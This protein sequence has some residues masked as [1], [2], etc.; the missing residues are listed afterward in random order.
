MRLIISCF[1]F[2]LPFITFSQ[3]KVSA[4]VKFN[5]QPFKEAIVIIEKKYKVRFSYSENLIDSSIKISLD[6]RE[7]TLEEVLIEIESQTNL[8]FERINVRYIIIKTKDT[9]ENLNNIQQLDKVLITS[10]LSRGISKNKDGSFQINPNKLQ[11]LPGVVEPDVLESLQQFPGVVSLNET[12]SGMNIRGGNFDQNQILWDGINIYHKGH[13][14]GMISQFNPHITE[15]VSLIAKGTDPKYGERVS[16]IIE[17]KSNTSIQN[18]FEAAAGINGINWDAMLKIPIIKDTLSFQT[19]FRRSLFDLHQSFTYKQLSNKVFQNTR[20]STVTNADNQ[21]SFSDAT[22]KINYK[23][24]NKNTL[25]FSAITINNSLNYILHEDDSNVSFT[26]RLTSS[27]YGVSL[28]WN[29]IYTENIQQETTAHYSNYAF[30]YN[31]I[32]SENEVQVSDFIKRNTILDSG[33]TTEFQFELSPNRKITFGYQYALKDAKYAFLNTSDLSFILDSD[34]S[35]RSTHAL[36]GKFNYRKID[37]WNISLGLRGSYFPE[38]HTV[39]LAPRI[40]ILKPIMKNL[41][42]QLT[43]ELKNQ[44]IS[45]VN[46][47]VFSNFSLENTIW[48][49][50]NTENV[51]IISSAQVSLGFLYA[52]NGLTFDVDSYY[53]SID[54]ITALS[55]GFLNPNM[56]NFNIGNQYIKGVEVFL[57]KKLNQLEAW[58]SYAY[59][60]SKSKYENLNNNQYFRSSTEINHAL[61]GSLLLK[62]KS[63][64]FMHAIGWQWRTGKPFTKS[65]LDDQGNIQFIDGINTGR[66]ANY[67]RLD[68]SSTYTFNFEKNKKLKGKLGISIRNILNTNILISK[69]F[70][71]NNDLST[72]IR[73]IDRF[74]LGFTPNLMFRISW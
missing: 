14:F 50:S 51:P 45:E 9:Q 54:N 32:T 46:E 69:E 44:I 43:G 16:S 23:P 60:D 65:S 30:D 6:S 5:Q 3:E 28:T 17:M 24:N 63:N 68:F 4:N 40:V 33:M 10:Y 59:S 19:S 58:L 27:N 31:F 72:P 36:F 70:T 48:R 1:F 29:K 7:R 47:T 66:L 2:L 21:F 37:S 74:S 73:E 57:K 12:A 49:L 20:I 71:G 64:K 67:Q 8:L 26:D 41:N 18:E 52:K 56:P 15:R 39:K 34:A 35:E 22:L 53:K 61:S 11:T 25:H 38:L 13:L 42:I 62:S 55:L